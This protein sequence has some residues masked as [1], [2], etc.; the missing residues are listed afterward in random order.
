MKLDRLFWGAILV[1][2]GGPLLFVACQTS[3]LAAG[4][5]YLKQGEVAD[6]RKQLEIAVL[7]DPGNGEAQFYLG[8]VRGLDGDYPGMARAFERS[9]E[10]TPTYHEEIADERH[11]YWTRVY[12]DGVR[13]AAGEG[14]DLATARG[15]FDTAT[16]IL[17]GRLR[18][19]RNRAAIDMRLGDRTAAV[20]AYRHILAQAPADTASAHL[21]GAALMSS[22]DEEGAARAFESVL[23]VDEHG[24]ALMNLAALQLRQGH[25]G[26][27]ATLLQRAIAV[28]PACFECHY[29][30]GNLHYQAGGYQMAHT[31]YEV[32]VEIRPDDVDARFNLAVADISLGNYDEA[33]PLLESLSREQPDS[34]VIWRELSKAYAAVGRDADSATALERAAALGP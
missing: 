28:D 29:N 10:I 15:H 31:H 24:G 8:R 34:G 20:E 18:A 19:W 13:A 27:A 7:A 23:E 26:H 14:A 11:H 4:K 5:L 33:L 30:L 17:P 3:A 25:G 21:L 2:G 1:I 6:A 32:A 12:N 16:R 9:W 22:G